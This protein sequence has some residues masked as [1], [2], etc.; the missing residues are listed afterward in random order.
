MNFRQNFFSCLF[1]NS[2]ACIPK[3]DAVLD[4]L[5]SARKTAL[6]YFTAVI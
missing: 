6:L 2:F 1:F 4:Q 5:A 3:Q